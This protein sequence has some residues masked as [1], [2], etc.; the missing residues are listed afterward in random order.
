MFEREFGI[1]HPREKKNGKVEK[2]AKDPWPKWLFND[3]SSNLRGENAWKKKYRFFFVVLKHLE[4]ILKSNEEK[5]IHLFVK[6]NSKNA[7]SENVVSFY[8]L[9]P[10][11]G[12]EPFFFCK[13]NRQES[14]KAEKREN[15][16]FD[17]KLI[18]KTDKTVERS[19]VE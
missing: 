6:T 19:G 16:F 9:P 1:E 18:V 17:K 5:V 3:D 15:I 11:L 2:F 10:T 7:T 8:G 13:C 4:A 12:I 14:R